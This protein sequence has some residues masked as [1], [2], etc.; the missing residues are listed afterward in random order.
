MVIPGA[1][2]SRSRNDDELPVAVEAVVAVVIAAAAAMATMR[3][4]KHALNSAHG[5]AH[6]S[7]DDASDRSTDRTGDTIAFIRAFLGATHDTLGV[8]GLSQARKA[9]EE[10]GACEE[11]AGRTTGRQRAGGDTNSVHLISQG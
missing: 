7:A 9:E 1:T 2:K 4:T 3:N 5:A 10:S 6:T 8:T 11:Q